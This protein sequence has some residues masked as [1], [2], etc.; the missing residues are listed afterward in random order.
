MIRTRLKGLCFLQD[1]G[2]DDVVGNSVDAFVTI[3]KFITAGFCLF[4]WFNY[5]LLIL[6]KNKHY[7]S[8]KHSRLQNR[9]QA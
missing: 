3:I 4:P 9:L 6:P 7:S 2:E 8:H 5:D 1:E